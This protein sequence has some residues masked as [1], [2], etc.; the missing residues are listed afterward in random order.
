[1]LINYDV[2][3]ALFHMHLAPISPCS[4]AESVFK[5]SLSERRNTFF[6]LLQ[7]GRKFYHVGSWTELFLLLIIF[8]F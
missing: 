8:T 2:C 3:S 7:V 4:N 6:F 5:T 1:M